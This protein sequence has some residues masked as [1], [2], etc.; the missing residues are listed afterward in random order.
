[1]N[2]FSSPFQFPSGVH[3]L[4]VRLSFWRNFIRGFLEERQM[5]QVHVIKQG[6]DRKQD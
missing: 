5:I 6:F 3:S 1:L 4:D 2:N